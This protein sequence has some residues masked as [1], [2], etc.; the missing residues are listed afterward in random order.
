RSGQGDAGWEWCGGGTALGAGMVARST[1]GARTLTADEF[2]ADI[3]TTNL[4][5]DELLVA[6]RLPL[7]P[8]DTRWGFYEF[9]RRAGD[10]AM[11][12]AV[13]HDRLTARAMTEP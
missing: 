8:P 13:T 6:V 1:R 7:L 4:A 5:E 2:F 12:M 3:M 9:S 10:F 11:A